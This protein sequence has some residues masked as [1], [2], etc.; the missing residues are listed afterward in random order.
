MKKIALLFIVTIFYTGL[1]FTQAS[2]SF[3]Y[4]RDIVLEE[5]N[6]YVRL[7]GADSDG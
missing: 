7:I 5:K 4:D 3:G 6:D 2:A 1:A